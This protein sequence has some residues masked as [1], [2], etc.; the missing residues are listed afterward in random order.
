[1][2]PVRLLPGTSAPL[3]LASKSITF[4][5]AAGFG[6]VGNVPLF[7]VTGS[8]ISVYILGIVTT[9]L[10][11][12]SGT[13]ALGTTTNTSEFIAATTATTLTTAAPI[14]MST[15]ATAGSMAMPALI[16]EQVV[17]ENIVMTAAVASGVT[18]GVMRIDMYWL[19]LG[20][21]GTVV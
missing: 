12:A 17:T 18:G 15:T 11:G 16:K 9:T 6:A 4:T 14:W 5:G 8:I 21:G 10:T 13:L 20:A 2:S 7:T 1:M 19:P 3:Y